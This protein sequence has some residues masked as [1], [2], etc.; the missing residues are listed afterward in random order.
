[1]ESAQGFDLRFEAEDGTLLPHEVEAYDAGAGALEAWV[2]LP[3]LSAAAGARLFL[4]YGKPGQTASAADP[5]ALWGDYLAIWHLPAT[6]AGSVAGDAG[7]LA[8]SVRLAGAGTLGR[9]DAA[10]LDGLPALTLQLRA[11]ADATGHERGLVNLGGFGDAGSALT[12]R[13]AGAGGALHARLRTTAGD[14][15]ITTE[16][17]AQGTGWQALALAWTSGDPRPSLHLDGVQLEAAQGS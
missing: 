3:R 9:G 10:F 14:A 15:T 13:Y 16:G 2:R 8:G 7:G 4:Y 5:A 1:M 6:A 11:K 12:L 17:G